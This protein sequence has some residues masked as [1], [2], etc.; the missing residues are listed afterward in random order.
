MV[1]FVA[2]EKKWVIQFLDRSEVTISFV[3]TSFNKKTPDGQITTITPKSRNF[4]N[5]TVTGY[6]DGKREEIPFELN[7]FS[8]KVKMAS[9]KI[10]DFYIN[11]EDVK[12]I[13]LQW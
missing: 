12:S 4:Y 10:G 9:G 6:K 13:F 7:G 11:V 2:E 3:D 1:S 8:G 5:G